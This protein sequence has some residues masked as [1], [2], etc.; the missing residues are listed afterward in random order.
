MMFAAQ[1]TQVW[2]SSSFDRCEQLTQW[3]RI[4]LEG[5]LVSEPSNKFPAL[6]GAWSLYCHVHQS[7]PLFLSCLPILFFEEPFYHHHHHLIHYAPRSS[8]WSFL[9]MS[10]HQNPVC[11]SPVPHT[12]HMPSPSNF[13]LFDHL[14]SVRCT[15]H[16]RYV[17]TKCNLK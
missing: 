14:T 10:S 11:S 3:S 13:H 2:N 1:A 8:K 12:C 16:D 4:I 9:P 15:N 17:K 7:L 6:Y 5:L